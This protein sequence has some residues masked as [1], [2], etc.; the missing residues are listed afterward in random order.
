MGY[1]IQK[2]ECWDFPGDPV[3]KTAFQS[4]DMSSIPGQ[5]T[6]FFKMWMS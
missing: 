4:G 6:K 3:G 5:G 1:H 2:H